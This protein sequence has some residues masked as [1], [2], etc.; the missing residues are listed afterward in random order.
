MLAIPK[1]HLQVPHS[2]SNDLNPS[3]STCPAFLKAHT[4][5]PKNNPASQ[6]NSLRS[7]A[8]SILR[9]STPVKS[10]GQKKLPRMFNSDLKSFRSERDLNANKSQT[11]KKMVQ[12]H[13]SSQLSS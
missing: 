9:S 7:S 11:G 5:T 1:M 8:S 13:D 4:K 10:I 12:K 6:N 2:V 3:K